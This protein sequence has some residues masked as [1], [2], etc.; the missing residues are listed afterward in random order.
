MDLQTHLRSLLASR[1]GSAV[2]HNGLYWRA[3]TATVDTGVAMAVQTTFA[4]ISAVVSL[5]NGYPVAGGPILIPDFVRLIVTATGATTSSSEWAVSIDNGNRFSSGGATLTNTPSFSGQLGKL[6]QTIVKGGALVMTAASGTRQVV[7]HGIT[8][9]QATP[10]FALFDELFFS[11]SDHN[12]MTGDSLTGGA[13]AGR[14][15]L[16]VRPIAIAPQDTGILHIWNVANAVTPPS[17]E[18]EVGWYEIDNPNA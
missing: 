15:G 13:T 14:I 1:S 4:D 12:Q 2:A 10:C 9:V 6:S 16:P 17:F 5:F 3:R 8:K 11:F 7:A 18:I